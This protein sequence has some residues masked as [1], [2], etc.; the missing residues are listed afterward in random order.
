MN[1]DFLKEGEEKIKITDIFNQHNYT[2]C[3]E[4]ESDRDHVITKACTA[5]YNKNHVNK[6]NNMT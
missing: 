5:D 3:G 6:K 1:L 4:A 2:Y